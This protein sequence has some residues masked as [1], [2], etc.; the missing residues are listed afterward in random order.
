MNTDTLHMHVLL[1]W[2]RR[3][4]KSD[5]LDSLLNRSNTTM[6]KV[7]NKTNNEIPTLGVIKQGD[8]LGSFLF[9][10]I[11]DKI[12]EDMASLNIGYRLKSKLISMNCFA[13]DA[14]ILAET[15]GDLQRQLFRFFQSGNQYK[16]N[17]PINKTKCMTFWK[18]SIRCKIEV[19]NKMVE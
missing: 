7:C 3:L 5:W 4:I 11:M 12:I 10:L 14:V 18:E 2:P 15:Q 1:T 6:I 9:N 19:S 8:C 17:I 16:M 13:G